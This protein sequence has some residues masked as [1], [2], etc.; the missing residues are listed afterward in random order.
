MKILHCKEY[1]PVDSLVWEEVESPEPQD[2]EVLIDIKAAAL[3][4]P[5]FLIVQGLYQFKP[6]LPFAPGNEG[7]GTI[8]KTGKNVTRFKEGD[9]VY[10]MAPH[11]AFAEQIC[12]NEFGVFPIPDEISFQLAASYQMAYGT[13]YHALVQR[14][15][16]SEGDEVLILGAS[17]GVGLAALDI[18][19]AKGARAVVGVSTE[20]KAKICRDYGAD[21]VI[22]YGTGPKD[23]EE[24]KAFSAELKSKSIKG[25]YDIIYD[26]IGDCYAEPAFRAIGWK[27]KYLVVGFAAGQIPKLPINLT[28]LKGA[29]VVGVFW[30]AFTGREFE[31]NQKNISDIN[32]MLSVGEIKP[33]I[34]KEI[35]MENAV[36]A[37][38]MI[39]SRGVVGKVVLVN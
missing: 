5:D 14:G 36:E 20:E 38:Q 32:R 10:F 21:E 37:I 29:S 35:P 3:N 33:L 27:G 7:A 12:I 23:K 6:E 25:G 9:R 4:F 24:A 18:V 15:D 39:G 30:G 17:G 1:G 26:P 34:S 19:K 31:E 11:G 16:L 13:S 22:V 8:K 2:N 28:L